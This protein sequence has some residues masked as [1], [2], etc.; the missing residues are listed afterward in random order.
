MM[1]E[2]FLH[3]IWRY[4]LFFQVDLSTTGREPLVVLHPG[5]Y[6][7]HA[8]PDFLDARIRIGDSLWAGHV[9]IHLRATDW[10]R[11]AH[12]GDPRYG[13]VILHVVWEDDAPVSLHVGGDLPVLVLN[14]ITFPGQWERYRN[15]LES[16]TTIPCSGSI[17]DVPQ[18]VITQWKDRL[19]AERL[20]R[21]SE[22]FIREWTNLR[23]DWEETFY[24]LIARA[25]GFR[26]NADPFY[27][28]SVHLPSTCLMRYRHDPVLVEA[29]LFGVSGLLQD[30]PAD[31]Y[32]RLLRHEFDFLRKKHQLTPLPPGAWN[33]GRIRPNNHPCLRIAQFASLIFFGGNF[34]RL[35]SEYSTPDELMV[36]LRGDVNEY[37]KGRFAFDDPGSGREMRIKGTGRMGED[38]AVNLLINSVA[39]ALAAYGKV[40]DNEKCIGRAVKLLE[41][42]GAEDN[43][44]TAGWRRLGIIPEHAA[45]SQALIQL[46]NE[47]C[48]G[49]R[50]LDCMIGI[51]LLRMNQC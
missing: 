37:W 38:S 41:I 7:R 4:R 33:T 44:V 1:T 46:T 28:L 48:A 45:D 21:K 42:C 23:G 50:C 5:Q 34:F 25:M 2:A 18:L 9:E 32:P 27:Q 49:K 10:N 39:P 20:Q 11:H 36:W 43:R 24:R 3:Y 14:G 22:D 12:Q 16:N 35:A 29:L 51:S 13:N 26:L 40:M 6:N 47:Y 15:W 19:L 17:G 30:H 31:D 8:G